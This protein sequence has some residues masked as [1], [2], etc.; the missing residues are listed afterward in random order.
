MEILNY[1]RMVL[2][3]KHDVTEMSECYKYLGSSY[4]NIKN[5]MKCLSAFGNAYINKQLLSFMKQDKI[6]CFQ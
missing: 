1:Y 5:T 3:M 2:K 4:P 6:N